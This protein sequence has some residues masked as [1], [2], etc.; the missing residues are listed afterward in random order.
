MSRKKVQTAAM[1]VF[2][3]NRTRTLAF[4]RIFDQTGGQGHPSNDRKELLRGA[5]VFAIGS[6]DSYLHDLVLEI[7]PEHGPSSAELAEALRAIA[8]EDPSLALRVALA[9]D[10]ETARAQFS[11]ALDEWLSKKSFH[12]PEAVVRA[13]SYVG[14]DCDWASID[15]ATGCDTATLLGRFT[16]MRH[17]IVHRG[18]KPSIVRA[19]AQACVDLTRDVANLMD[20]TVCSSIHG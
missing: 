2:K 17:E 5:V 10:L 20:V 18:R 1:K 6:L 19:D 7:V 16:T 11:G 9:G 4:L 3:V 12:G 14:I 15:E 13:S 8:K